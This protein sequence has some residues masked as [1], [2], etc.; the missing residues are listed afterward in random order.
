LEEQLGAAEVVGVDVIQAMINI[1]QAK[2]KSQPLG[3]KKNALIIATPNKLNSYDLFS[4]KICFEFCTIVSLLLLNRKRKKLS[5]NTF[6]RHN[7][8]TLC[9]YCEK[10]S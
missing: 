8:F 10:R 1:A 9:F 2:E 5:L 3:R 7:M 6:L 4:Y